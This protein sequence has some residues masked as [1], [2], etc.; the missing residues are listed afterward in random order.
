MYKPHKHGHVKLKKQVVRP[1]RGRTVYH[2]HGHERNVVVKRRLP[3]RRP[4]RVR[5]PARPG[6]NYFWVDGYYEWNARRGRY[7]WIDGVWVKRRPGY[8]YRQGSW[9]NVEGGIT[10][11][12]AIWIRL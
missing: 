3:S 5:K 10:W 4:V 8:R 11:R 1:G 9:I 2:G 7:V 12:P 6:R